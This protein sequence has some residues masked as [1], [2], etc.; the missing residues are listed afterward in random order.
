MLVQISDNLYIII[1]FYQIIRT[2]KPLL[3]QILLEKSSYYNSFLVTQ[4][5]QQLHRLFPY[6][7][8]HLVNVIVIDFI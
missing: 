1:Q 8:W 4:M 3:Y 5:V 2:C 7:G 6:K